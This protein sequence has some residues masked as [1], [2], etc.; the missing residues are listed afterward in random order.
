VK[1]QNPNDNF[2]SVQDLILDRIDNAIALFNADFQLVLF[3][4]KLVQVWGL[5]ADWLSQK[6]HFDE[7]ADLCIARGYWA[8]KHAQ[9]LQ[10]SLENRELPQN[11]FC[12]AQHNGIYVEIEVTQTENGGKLFN[13]RDLTNYQQSKA[14]LHYEVQRLSFLLGLTE[15]LQPATDL[16]QI[17][18]FALS[19]LVETMGAGFGDV[20]V[21]SGEGENR[22][23]GTITNEISSE[24]IATYGVPA[25][26]KM[27]EV[28]K[29]GI[30]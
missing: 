21:I 10:D 7:I 2:N 6:P 27:A 28:L 12:I 8:E 30:P 20:K 5:A 19:Y 24:F 16:R 23:A 9:Q 29:Q 26:E 4:Q 18:Q 14:S 22:S 1:S 17:G 15:H 3:N 13:L 11:S 25:I